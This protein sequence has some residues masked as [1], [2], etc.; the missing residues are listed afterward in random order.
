MTMR[1][2]TRGRA[3]VWHVQARDD[4]DWVTMET[5]DCICFQ[6][7][8]PAP[9]SYG[10]A[11]NSAKKYEE[12]EGKGNVRIVGAVLGGVMWPLGAVIQRGPSPWVNYRKKLLDLESTMIH[13]EVVL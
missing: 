8:A 10:C 11:V 4:E 1:M 3:K 7:W 6:R 12:L 5:T 13:E 2:L 9:C